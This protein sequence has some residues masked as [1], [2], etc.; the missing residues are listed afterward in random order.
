MLMENKKKEEESS[1]LID[2]TVPYAGVSIFGSKY[3]PP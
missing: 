3:M 2:L 1:I